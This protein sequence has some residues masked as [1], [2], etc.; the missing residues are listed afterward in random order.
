[1]KLTGSDFIHGYISP[2]IPTSAH[3]TMTSTDIRPFN[4]VIIDTAANRRSIIS[5]A[6]F[7]TYQHEF[8]RKIP[9]SPARKYVKGISGKSRALDEVTI[10]VSFTNLNLILDIEFSILGDDMPSLLC[11]KDLIENGLDI[12]LQGGYLYIGNAQ[13]PLTLNNYFFI[14]KWS[15]GSIPYVIYTEDELRKIHRTFGHPS[16]TSTHNLLRRA[17]DEP[18]KPEV[19][20]QFEIIDENCRICRRKSSDPPFFKLTMGTGDLKFNHRVI[21]DTM[22][23]DGRALLH[24]IDE[25]THFPAAIFLRDQSAAEIWK[26][27]M[28]L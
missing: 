7:H 13:E 1:M 21:A 2:N 14:Y 16:V 17:S 26:Q 19:R 12:S 28:Q 15:A 11:N 9:I 6:Q 22:F 8:G 24:I 4:R 25:A 5:L 10:Q 18:P 23:L 20:R 3:L 27:L